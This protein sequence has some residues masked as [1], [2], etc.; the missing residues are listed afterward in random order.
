MSSIVLLSLFI[1]IIYW[2]TLAGEIQFLVTSSAVYML[3]FPKQVSSL[4]CFLDCSFFFFSAVCVG[5]G[6]THLQRAG[7]VKGAPGY[8]LEAGC[9]LFKQAAWTHEVMGM[10]TQIVG[11][12]QP[13]AT[14]N[15]HSLRSRWGRCES[16]E[17]SVS[18]AECPA[19]APDPATLCTLRA[20]C[21]WRPR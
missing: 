16:E 4:T 20:R 2:Q 15:H 19:M 18:P 3:F 5:Q 13:P 21:G 12:C 17:L 11:K 6:L 1:I 10:R 9:L 8:R 14:S 7:R